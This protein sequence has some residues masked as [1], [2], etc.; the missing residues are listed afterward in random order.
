MQFSQNEVEHLQQLL[1]HNKEHQEVDSYKSKL[2]I[3]FDRYMTTPRLRTQMNAL[4]LTVL[5]DYEENLI[6]QSLV[7]S[8]DYI[9]DTII[10]FRVDNNESSYA[11]FSTTFFWYDNVPD[12]NMNILPAHVILQHFLTTELGLV[13]K[14]ESA[15]MDV[16]LDELLR[17][18]IENFRSKL[19][20]VTRNFCPITNESVMPRTADE[21]KLLASIDELP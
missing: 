2:G 8:L 16:T 20:Y 3:V 10:Q 19:M 13:L 11:F 17:A 14:S 9:F 6:W 21:I 1:D 12:I 7:L 4:S 18:D 15:P 5:D